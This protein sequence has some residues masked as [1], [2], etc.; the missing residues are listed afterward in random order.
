MCPCHVGGELSPQFIHVSTKALKEFHPAILE[1]AGLCSPSD[2][3]RREFFLHGLG[4]GFAAREQSCP[5]VFRAVGPRSAQ[6]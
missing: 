5:H 4:P 1:S 3:V 6:R 2:F